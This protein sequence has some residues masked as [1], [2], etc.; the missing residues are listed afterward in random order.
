[1][2]SPRPVLLLSFA[3]SLAAAWPPPDMPDEAQFKLLQKQARAGH[4]APAAKAPAPVLAP[5]TPVAASEA[6]AKA[7]LDRFQRAFFLGG[8]AFGKQMAEADVFLLHNPD[9][10]TV[11][12]TWSSAVDG[13]GRSLLAPDAAP[14]ELDLRSGQVVVPLADPDDEAPVVKATG[15]VTVEAPSGFDELTLPCA[16]PGKAARSGRIT[17]TVE[18]CAADV[19][20]ALADGLEEADQ[21]VPLD[22][23]RRALASGES[24]RMTLFSGKSFEDLTY[25]EFKKGPGTSVRLETRAKGTVA[26]VRLLHPRGV[27]KAELDVVATPEPTLADYGPASRVRYQA[28]AAPLPPF[29]QLDESAL[30]LSLESGRSCAVMGYN[31]PGLVLVLPVAANSLLVRAE[32]ATPR[33]TGGPKAGF[34]VEENGLDEQRLRYRWTLRGT[35][36]APLSFKTLEARATVKYPLSLV[37][38]V[39]RKGDAGVVID[40]HRVTVALAEGEELAE[41]AFGKVQGIV[42][43]DA[44]GRPLKPF[45]ML[46]ID[47]EGVHAAF[48]GPVARVE[49]S[50]VAGWIER[51]LT[52]KLKPAPLRPADRAGLCD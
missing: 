8:K 6:E 38:R 1:M 33:L 37:K 24:I 16:E 11:R 4:L 26:F 29:A 51:V 9:F 49:V 12:V 15:R 32:L 17:L 13:K 20:V 18:K 42:A 52:A 23:D 27:R 21:V 22:A 31:A 10:T 46:E 41:G 3:V 7:A 35:G 30:A 40:G 39:L 44:A 43:Q 19:F 45:G 25:D 36:A 50:T 47:G 2:R 48:M 14:E 34:T 28:P 5:S